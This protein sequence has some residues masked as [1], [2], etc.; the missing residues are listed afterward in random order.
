MPPSKDRSATT[1]PAAAL[2]ARRMQ[3][4][5]HKA[6]SVLGVLANENRLVLMCQLSQGE[7]S[8][9]QLEEALQIRQPTLSQQLA[10]LRAE[11]LV[12]TRREGRNIY[13]SVA[14]AKV[15]AVLETLY[16]LYC[17]KPPS[18]TP[19]PQTGARDPAGGN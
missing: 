13:Y 5:A 3:A 15:L 14:D 1:P 12:R 10:V 17:P 16:A 4:A 2:D 7:K 11:K 18:P 9:T 6:S 8:V 19:R